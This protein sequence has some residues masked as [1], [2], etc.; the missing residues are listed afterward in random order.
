[1]FTVAIT[2]YNRQQLL[3]RAIQSALSQRWPGLELLVVDDASTDGTADFMQNSF[4][5]IQ[6]LQQSQNRGPGAA[7]NR[8]LKEATEPWV[9]FL[10]DDDTLTAGAISRVA[11]CLVQFPNASRYPVLQFARSNATT[12]TPFFVAGM[13]DYMTERL[14]GD[15]VPVVN[16][17]YFLSE[18]L[19][20]PELGTVGGEGLLWWR[21]AEHYGIPTWASKI[22]ELHSDA[23][24]RMTS[25]D[26]QLCHAREFAELQEHTLTEFGDVLLTKFPAYYLKKR[27]GGATYRLLAGE[28]SAAREHIRLALRQRISFR[29][30]CL[31]LLTHMP[32]ALVRGC[33]TLYRRQEA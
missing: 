1:M 17:R 24:Y 29:A 22:A 21:I 14:K 33:Y 6:L 31:L 30:L 19:A 5:R 9:V 20:Y 15:F 23:Q 8:A 27:L 16:R 7:R 32:R 3:G 28:P 25:T 18:G 11:E 4:P 13:A 12:D 10:D 26:Y 2:T